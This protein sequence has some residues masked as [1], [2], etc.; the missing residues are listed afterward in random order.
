VLYAT[1]GL[2]PFT[3]GGL[4]LALGILYSWRRIRLKAIPVADLVSHTLMLAALQLLCAYAA[5]RPQGLDWLVPCLLVVAA[6]AYGQLVNQVRD[7][8]VDRQ[9]GINH[10]A[11]RVGRGVAQILM[12]ATVVV[13]AVALLAMLW[14]G[15][16]PL[17]VVVLFAVLTAATMLGVTRRTSLPGSVAAI[18][19]ADPDH[20]H[21]VLH[22]P[23]L[24]SG[25]IA[26]L[27]WLIAG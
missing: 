18:S 1:L 19:L 27:A 15:I 21:A 20:T 11:A 24:A 26:L 17:W 7:L 4:C 14:L 12:V 13:A 9:A 16:M 10:T 23:V 3:F 22:V 8:D 6:S 5:F 2:W 25:T